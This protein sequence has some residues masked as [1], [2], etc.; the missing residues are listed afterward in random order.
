MITPEQHISE[1]L[2]H[3]PPHMMAPGGGRLDGERRVWSGNRSTMSSSLYSCAVHLAA[4]PT[5]LAPFL[6]I[7]ADAESA[8]GFSSRRALAQEV[9]ASVWQEASSPT[10]SHLHCWGAR[11]MAHASNDNT[12]LPL[13]GGGNGHISLAPKPSPTYL[14]KGRR[15]TAKSPIHQLNRHA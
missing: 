7:A 6:P 12:R 14:A 13:K 10:C 9:R 3:V 5:N 8:H 1:L 4:R 2:L 11:L 15:T